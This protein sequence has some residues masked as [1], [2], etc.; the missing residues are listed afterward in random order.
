MTIDWER[1]IYNSGDVFLPASIK[2]MLDKY[3]YTTPTQS[4]YINGWT[5]LH[6]LSGMIIGAIYLYLGK[7]LNF[8]YYHLFIIHTIWELWQMLIGMSNPWKFSGHSNLI[9]IFVD[10]LV[11][12]LG[13]YITLQ[14]Y[15]NLSLG[16]KLFK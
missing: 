8:Y 4:F 6:C 9:D 3:I 16:Y 11:F 5:F 2:K 13:S 1:A 15:Y 10:T 7:N 14:I 12:M